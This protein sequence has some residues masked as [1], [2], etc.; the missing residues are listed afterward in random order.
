MVRSVEKPFSGKECQRLRLGRNGLTASF[1]LFALTVRGN[2]PCPQGSKGTPSGNHGLGPSDHPCDSVCWRMPWTSS[3]ASRWT[4]LS[5][6]FVRLP[7]MLRAALSGQL[8]QA[9]HTRRIARC[10]QPVG[11]FQDGDPLVLVTLSQS[12]SDSRLIGMPRQSGCL[13]SP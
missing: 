4:F 1:T 8:V 9:Q 10:R 5:R 2:P 3:G 7:S 11:D 6:V 12:T 13:M